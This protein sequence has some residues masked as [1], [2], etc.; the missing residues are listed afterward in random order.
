LASA[1]SALVCASAF[2][3]ARPSRAA[4]PAEAARRASMAFALLLSF[5]GAISLASGVAY[6]G[7]AVVLTVLGVYACDLPFYG[8]VAYV[9]GA[10]LV[11]PIAREGH[12]LGRRSS[13]DASQRLITTGA[14][15]ATL[16]VLPSLAG[17]SSDES[18]AMVSAFAIGAT[19]LG[20][21]WVVA[22][23]ASAHRLLARVR[24]GRLEGYRV[25]GPATVDERRSLTPLF[26]EYGDDQPMDTLVRLTDVRSGAY[27][28]AP[29]EEPV[30]LVP[31]L[32]ARVTETAPALVAVIV[33]TAQALML[34]V[35]WTVAGG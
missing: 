10:I 18:L 25:R 28:E 23:H 14:L 17:A 20:C 16:A 33:P 4:S 8:F 13:H 24:T 34:L 11:A 32:E 3:I 6:R 1:F 5:V 30:A 19:W 27:R 31:A 29:L 26:S 2:A 15:V 22:S 9:T 21:M 35:A 7:P 12:R